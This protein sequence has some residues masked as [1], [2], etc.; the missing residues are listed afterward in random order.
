MTEQQGMTH[1]GTF[2][3][4]KTVPGVSPGVVYA[5]VAENEDILVAIKPEASVVLFDQLRRFFQI[6]FRI[7]VRPQIGKVLPERDALAALLNIGHLSTRTSSAGGPPRVVGTVRVPVCG[8]TLSP[9]VIQDA[10]TEHKLIEMLVA[11][12]YERLSGAGLKI[13][14]PEPALVEMARERFLDMIPDTKTPLPESK[15]YFGKDSYYPPEA[16]GPPK[17]DYEGGEDGDVDQGGDGPY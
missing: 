17:P 11:G 12:L 14:L 6:G 10:I 9:W 8:L 4:V 2:T 5:V 16:S 13:I 7:H 15:C 1:E 3:E